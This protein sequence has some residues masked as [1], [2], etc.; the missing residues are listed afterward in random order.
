M[1]DAPLPYQYAHFLK[2]LMPN[3]LDYEIYNSLGFP[4]HAKSEFYRQLVGHLN[5]SS[6]EFVVAPGIKGM[7]M[8]VF[9]LPSYNIVFKIIKDKFAPPKE[10]THQIVREKYRLVSRHARIG[11]MADTQEFDN[12]I[13]PLNRFSKELLD[14]LQKVAPSQIEIRDDKLL[15]RHLYTELS[16]IHI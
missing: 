1:V 11:R 5:N 8:S 12:L 14:E 6:D 13:F 4:K 7:V 2:H 16:L 3:K 15:I 9:T 10:V